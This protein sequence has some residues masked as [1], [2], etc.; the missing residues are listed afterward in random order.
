MKRCS[1]AKCKLVFPQ[2]VRLLRKLLEN[3][4]KGEMKILSFTL[5]N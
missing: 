2:L 4:F 5:V 1:D 3:Y